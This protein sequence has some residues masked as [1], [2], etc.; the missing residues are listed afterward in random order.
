MNLTQQNFPFPPPPP[1]SGENAKKGFHGPETRLLLS[2]R[3]KL[4][5]LEQGGLGIPAAVLKKGAVIGLILGATL[6]LALSFVLQLA[7]SLPTTSWALLA[8]I[9][10]ITEEIFKALSIL[11]VA[12]FIWKKIPSRRQ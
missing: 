10:P 6:S 8:L 7:T 4:T 9:A 3:K 12:V 5:I 11:I 1:P 2:V